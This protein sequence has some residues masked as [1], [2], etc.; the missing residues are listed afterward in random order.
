MGLMEETGARVRSG[1]PP[2]DDVVTGV[3]TRKVAAELGTP[4]RRVRDQD[5]CSPL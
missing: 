3:T 1:R 4:K 5:R 2:T